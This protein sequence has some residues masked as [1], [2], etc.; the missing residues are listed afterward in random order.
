M[1]IL[2]HHVIFDSIRSSS[3][4]VR[5]KVLSLN[6][7]NS[8]STVVPKEYFMVK[9]DTSRI[10]NEKIEI[11]PTNLIVF[12]IDAISEACRNRNI[13]RQK[14][15]IIVTIKP[16]FNDFSNFFLLLLTSSILGILLS[17]NKCAYCPNR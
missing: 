6:Y 13:A 17:L 8:S 3:L 7:F 2:I 5:P 4:S 1:S 9:K 11:P 12:F 15:M 16:I 10:N 14:T